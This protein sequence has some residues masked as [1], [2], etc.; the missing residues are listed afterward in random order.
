MFIFSLSTLAIMAL[1]RFGPDIPF[2]RTLKTCLLKW[3][4]DWIANHKRQHA[5]QLAILLILCLGSW[6]LVLMFGSEF[7]WV[8]AGDLALYL[9]VLV[10]S[11]LVTAQVKI[12]SAC[13][14]ACNIVSQRAQRLWSRVRTSSRET[15][16]RK[17]SRGAPDNDDDVASRTRKLAA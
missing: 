10:M 15:I 3:P 7:A 11:F 5:I 1:M 17:P 9:D 16:T 12:K 4:L 8:Y 2:T 14:L 13:R 6:E